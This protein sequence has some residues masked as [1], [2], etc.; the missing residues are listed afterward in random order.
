MLFLI[1]GI[2][3]IDLLVIIINSSG[4]IKP[5]KDKKQCNSWF[6]Y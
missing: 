2:I 6:Y 3:L 1:I 5:L 4:K